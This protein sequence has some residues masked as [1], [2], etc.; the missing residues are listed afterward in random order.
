MKR[1]MIAL[2]TATLVATLPLAAMAQD[3]GSHGNHDKKKEH[4]MHSQADHGSAHDS[5]IQI[6]E[7]T[8]DGVE[9]MA[10]LNDIGEAMAK[11]K[12]KETH[13]F[14]MMFMG[15]DGAIE[16]GT[17]AAKIVD[18][19]GKEGEAIRLVA[20]D[21]HFGADIVLPEKGDYLFKVG[22]RLP[23]GKTRQYEFRY[24]LK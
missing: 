19:A 14:I 5:M 8:I 23:D 7:Q 4:A 1:T 24:T 20:M 2:L 15:K 12:M 13:H 10:H 6:G 9:G 11:M 22:T 17:A 16:T 3:H 18:P 21:G